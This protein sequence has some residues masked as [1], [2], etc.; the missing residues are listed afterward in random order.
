MA[1]G[2]GGRIGERA[3]GAVGGGEGQ[4]GGEGRR[5]GEGQTAVG[6]SGG[7]TWRQMNLHVCLC[8]QEDGGRK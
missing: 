5:E 3:G 6:G 2:W 8:E 7:G 1:G 4:G